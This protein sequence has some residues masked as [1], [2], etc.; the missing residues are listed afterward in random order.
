MSSKAFFV[1]FLA[2]SAVTAQ[3]TYTGCHNHSSVEWCYGGDGLE[4]ALITYSLTTSTAAS[5]PATASATATST[6]D[7]A[8]VTG[9]HSHGSDV[10]CINAAGEEVSVSLT[11][12]P[13][14][15]LPAQYTDCHTHDSTQ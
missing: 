3:T 5:E 12:T 13:T 10:Y 11:A 6:G 9:C 15:E 14:G 7:S 4:T 8:A 2:F 1:T